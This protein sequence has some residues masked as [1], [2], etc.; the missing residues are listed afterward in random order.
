MN[1]QRTIF[2]QLLDHLPLHEF[3][4]C[5]DRY[6]GN[7][8]ARSLSC[9]D[10]LLAMMFGQLTFRDSLRDV[11]TCLQTQGRKL[12][13]CGIRGTISRSTLADANE[14]RDWRI[15]ADFANI[16]IAQ[17]RHLY[18]K[19]DVGLALVNT[20]YA[21]DST[22][23]DLC[24]SIFPWAQF[25]RHKSAVKLHTLIDLRGNIPCFVRL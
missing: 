22:T 25:R 19:E 23:I 9:L 10:Q 24:L 13:H 1:S 15:Y 14:R 21:F 18:V 4:R 5:V 3:R 12:Y 7:R 11:V 20:A 16:L 8:R 17:A 2:A 6:R